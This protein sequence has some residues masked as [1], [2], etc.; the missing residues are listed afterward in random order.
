M[1]EAR[2]INV[3]THARMRNSAVKGTMEFTSEFFVQDGP[4]PK[5]KFGFVVTDLVTAHHLATDTKDAKEFWMIAIA[6]IIRKQ[7]KEAKFFAEDQ[8]LDED[9]AYQARLANYYKQVGR[10]PAQRHKSIV[11]RRAAQLMAEAIE[12]E[13]KLAQAKDAAER[14]KARLEQE[15]LKREADEMSRKAET[16]ATMDSIVEESLVMGDTSRSMQ[17]LFS[18]DSETVGDDDEDD[19]MFLPTPPT[20][21]DS[22][23]SVRPEPPAM[24]PR[25][26]SLLD[27]DAAPWATLSEQ[28]KPS[29][30]ATA[31]VSSSVVAEPPRAAESVADARKPSLA[32]TLPPRK[33]SLIPTSPAAKAAELPAEPQ[34]FPG[35]APS[36]RKASMLPEL[37]ARKASVIAQRAVEEPP[38]RPAVA[39]PVPAPAPAPKPVVAAA[40]AAAPKPAMAAA[41]PAAQTPSS[42]A[43]KAEPKAGIAGKLGMWQKK[44]EEHQEKQSNNVF[45]AAYAGAKR[46]VGDSYGKAPEGSKTEERANAAAQWVELEIAK[47]VEVIKEIGAYDAAEGGVATVCFGPLFYH[48]QDISDTLVGILMRAKKRKLLKYQ[49]DML[50][51]GAHD[52]VK[53]TVL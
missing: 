12:A 39:K 15:R 19:D 37:P 45:S 26:P 27:D 6:N 20:G 38:A 25:K 3:I 21:F 28:R 31:A 51:Q 34:P 22:P 47:L 41:S 9:E 7:L 44:V 53:I 4:A 1:Y 50:F 48:Y 17:N 13:T 33:A 42:S 2:R 10:A 24:P 29:F 32:P 11:D 18:D 40:V 16:A 36:P 5:G 49:G 35:E 30:L 46:A 52:K 23:S 43:D 8:K 14:D